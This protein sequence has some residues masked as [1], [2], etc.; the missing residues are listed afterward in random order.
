MS[1][2]FYFCFKMNTM[3]ANPWALGLDTKEEAARL[4]GLRKWE[5]FPTWE[6]ARDW[7]VEFERGRQHGSV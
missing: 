2:K 4:M 1:N 3:D 7:A 6:A 5:F